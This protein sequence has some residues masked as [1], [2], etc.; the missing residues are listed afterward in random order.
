METLNPSPDSPFWSLPLSFQPRVDAMGMS[1]VGILPEERYLPVPTWQIG[2]FEGET[3][4]ELTR[5]KLTWRWSI[6]PRSVLVIPPRS[7]RVY[8]TPRRV[9]HYYASFR[10]PRGGR[11]PEPPAD[12]APVIPLGVEAA[13]IERDFSAA[14][15]LCVSDPHE[16]DLLI[17]LILRRL[18]RLSRDMGSGRG[19]SASVVKCA[20]DR[21][22]RHLVD[23]DLTPEALAGEAGLSRRRL[24]QLFTEA[25][26]CPVA[27][28]IREQRLARAARLLEETSIPIGVVGEVTGL[29]DPHQ[30]NKSI[31][32][33]TGL[34]PTEVRGQA[35]RRLSG[36]ASRKR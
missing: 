6:A 26:G 16:S 28:W 9:M 3:T 23:S 24:D 5:G 2:L 27:A 8:S 31:R 36:G 33:A 35:T 1:S 30:F 32:R 20:M 13:T 4:V 29:G 17:W 10:F 34:S 21:I 25:V 11:R 7:T 19:S 18:A 15:D 12:L 22:R 14:I